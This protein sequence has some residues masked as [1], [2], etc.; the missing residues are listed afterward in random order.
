MK[1]DKINTSSVLDDES[2]KFSKQVCSVAEAMETEDFTK[3]F[4]DNLRKFEEW[5][6]SML[7][8]MKEI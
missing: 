2:D 1:N 5:H 3:E 7:D 8:K 4:E 6:N